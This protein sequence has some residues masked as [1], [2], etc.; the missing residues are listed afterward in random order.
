MRRVAKT[1]GQAGD[2]ALR[3]VLL[4]RG[5]ALSP[6]S[7][8]GGAFHDLKTSLE[9]GKIQGWES[10]G[11]EEYHLPKG[12]SGLKRLWMR[13][14]QHPRKVARAIGT[15]HSAKKV[16]LVHVADQE[17]AHLIPKRSPV[18]VI[19]YVHDF[20]HLLPSVMNLNGERIEVGEQRPGIIRKRDLKRLMKGLRRADGFVCNTKAT[21]ALC[22]QHF[23]K[24]PLL[25]VA[26]GLDV[27]QYAPPSI[28]PKPP[29]SL[30]E[31]A[32]HLL[33]VGSHDPRKRLKFII[34]IIASLPEKQRQEIQVHHVGGDE[35]PYGGPN[36]SEMAA[37]SNITWHNVGSEVPDDELNLYRWHTEVL[38]F[39]S[40]AEGFGYP[41]VESMAAGQPALA[42]NLPAHNELMPEGTCLEAE[43]ESAWREAILNVHAAWASREGAQRHPDAALMEHVNFLSPERFHSGMQEAWTL[44]ASK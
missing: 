11:C 15:L 22:R 9:S 2:D 6:H 32:C 38:L 23:P 34:Q 12:S 39:A 13:W 16:D 42:S 3:R 10:A 17:Q 37:A 44:H 26:Y 14:F 28:L 41:P 5:G 29:T 19:V 40:A 25:R 35:C 30:Q 43:D 21:E 7:G 18:P 24:M 33:V 1:M 20:F 27:T 36:A 4:V 31:H 8:L